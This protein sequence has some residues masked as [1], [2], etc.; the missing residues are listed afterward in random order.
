MNQ[1][2]TVVARL[3]RRIRQA[4]SAGFQVRM[5]V[6]DDEQAG[7]C[8]VG[9]TRILFVNLSNTAAE[10]LAQVEETLRDFADSVS[11]A[12][13]VEPVDIGKTAA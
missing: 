7:W 1:D 13:A 4:K 11:R 10:Q 3:R 9:R 5:E 12:E 6:L 2:D 8:Q